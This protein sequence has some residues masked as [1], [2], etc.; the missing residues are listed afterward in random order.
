MSRHP[1]ALNNTLISD[2]MK[3]RINVCSPAGMTLVL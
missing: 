1:D 3:L 2:T